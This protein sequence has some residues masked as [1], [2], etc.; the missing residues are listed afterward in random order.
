MASRRNRYTP[1]PQLQGPT[2]PSPVPARAE[3]RTVLEQAAEP[4]LLVAVSA[5]R[6]RRVWQRCQAIFPKK[7]MH[8]FVVGDTAGGDSDTPHDTLRDYGY[9]LC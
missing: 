2:V 3:G 4:P 5:Q 1:C 6:A 7:H 8:F 9:L